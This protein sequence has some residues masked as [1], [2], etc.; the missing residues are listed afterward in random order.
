METNNSEFRHYEYLAD[1]IRLNLICGTAPKEPVNQET[2][3]NNLHTHIWYELFFDNNQSLTFHLEEKDITVPAG[4]FLLVKP[5]VY[6]YV[7]SDECT[8]TFSFCVNAKTK[9]AA[10]HPIIKNLKFP[11]SKIFKADK[12][13]LMLIDLINDAVSRRNSSEICNYIFGLL[14]HMCDMQSVGDDIV[15]ADSDIARI[16]KIDMLL[17][18]Y[19]ESNTPFTLSSLAKEINISARQLSR[20]FYTHYKCSFSEKIT[21]LKVLRAA[22]LLYEG[23]TIAQASESVGYSSTKGFYSAFKSIFGITPGEYRSNFNK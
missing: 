22:H 8:N 18:S 14:L 6:H 12:S 13:S 1:G 4:H 19:I 5:G 9:I 17:T 10:T 2:Y 11:N 7:T 20:I 15:S 3:T 16:F 21:E 23:K